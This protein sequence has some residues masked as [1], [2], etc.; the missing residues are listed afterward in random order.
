M[1]VM[2]CMCCR[3]ASEGTS[4]RA[5]GGCALSQPS[6]GCDLPRHD[7]LPLPVTHWVVDHRWNSM[8]QGSLPPGAWQ[9]CTIV[10]CSWLSSIAVH[11]DDSV[12]MHHTV[13]RRWAQQTTWRGWPLARR[14]SPASPWCGWPSSP[15]SPQLTATA[16]TG[17]ARN[18]AQSCAQHNSVCIAARLRASAAQINRCSMEAPRHE[19]FQSGDIHGV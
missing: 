9:R 3:A 19:Q 17:A 8:F 5:P 7:V 16:M 10:L 2:Y 12:F 4:R 18:H 6:S 1:L 13:F 14:S 15:F 11:R